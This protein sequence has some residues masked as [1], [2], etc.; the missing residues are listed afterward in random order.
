M[1]TMNGWCLIL[2]ESVTWQQLQGQLR[3]QDTISWRSWLGILIL[4]L[5]V[6][7]LI[8]LSRWLASRDPMLGGPN[9]QLLFNELATAHGLSWRE[10]W[11]LKRT[12]RAARLEHPVHV[13]L[14]PSI[15]D[16]AETGRR[17]VHV[18]PRI[19][20]VRGKLFTGGSAS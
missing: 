16:N 3:H 13:F 8:G 1:N 11:L 9:S 19:Q 12:A 17:L 6:A 2:A 7:G 4:A 10:K 5:F 14:D 15:F 18:W 20:E